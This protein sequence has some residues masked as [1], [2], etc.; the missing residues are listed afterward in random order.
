[1]TAPVQ[2]G[3]VLAG[4]FRVERVLG[5]G[6]MGVVVSAWHLQL[7]ERVALK[8]MLPDALSNQEAVARFA[9]EA[10]AA[11]KIKSEHVAR[12]SDVGTLDNGAPYMVMEFLE[13]DD[14]HQL[15]QRMGPLPIEQA[16][17]YLLQACEAIAEA[18]SIGIVHRDL[19][20]A[21]LF[22]IRRRDGSSSVKVL[23]F[24]ISK[25]GPS[26]FDM[27][28]T[29]AVMG[30]P[31]Y[32][33]PEQ[34]ESSKNADHR[35]DIWALGITLYE[36]LSCSKPFNGDTLP[37]LVLAVMSK[38]PAAIAT[39]RAGIPAGLEAVIRKSLE[40]DRNQRFQTIGHFAEALLPFAPRR[41]RLSVERISGLM[42]AAGLGGTA[43]A[44]PPSSDPPPAEEDEGKPA[45]QASW[46]QTSPRVSRGRKAL[47][48]V[49]ALVVLGGAGAAAFVL[50]APLPAEH[51]EHAA[52]AAPPA[53]TAAPVAEPA[54]PAETARAP[55]TVSVTPA[56][57]A[58]Q[59][60]AMP[61]PPRIAPVHLAPRPAKPSASV[62]HTAEAP[63]KVVPVEPAPRPAATPPPST[64]F[65]DRK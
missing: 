42:Q 55:D 10:R 15:L 57:P 17:D 46:G 19:K 41:S 18:H 63:V 14:L 61:E 2:P 33:S 13:G 51:E 7:E 47:W 54:K 50:R 49:V 22:V 43:L 37:E 40:K 21:N 45:T 62:A 20:P 32:M 26:Q 27:T 48:S 4:K 31:M 39:H 60:A 56:A 8:F 34:L 29:S 64:I 23:D 36:L 6:G 24:G 16:V 44:P 25:A 30:S 28:R 1:M 9:R 5:M 38:Q 12:V 35:T 11:V 58:P 59:I 53:P 65:D 52:S 3:D